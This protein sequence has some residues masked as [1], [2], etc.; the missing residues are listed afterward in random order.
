MMVEASP[1]FSFGVLSPSFKGNEG[2]F[3]RA[4][5]ATNG[6]TFLKDLKCELFGTG[7]QP[8]ECR[9]CHHE[10][11]NQGP[12]CHTAIEKEWYSQQ[13]QKVIVEWFKITNFWQRAN[14]GIIRN[15]LYNSSL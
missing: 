14:E 15:Q 8:L 6:C 10:R 11:R 5:F 4:E 1:E 2:G 7:V 13:G 12:E 9:Y 3:A